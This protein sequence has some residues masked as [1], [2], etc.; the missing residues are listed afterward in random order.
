MRLLVGDNF[1][2]PA[3]AF[4]PWVFK[5]RPNQQASGT[6][7]LFGLLSTVFIQYL[8][9]HISWTIS[10]HVGFHLHYWPR[11]LGLSCP[12]ECLARCTLGQFQ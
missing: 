6:K 7:E 9:A 4:T 10:F 3:G 12:K 11:S 1:G 5:L 2:A 8:L